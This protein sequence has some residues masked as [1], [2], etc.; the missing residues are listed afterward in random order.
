MVHASQTGDIGKIDDQF[1]QFIYIKDRIK[2]MYISGGENVYPAE[3]EDELNKM[4]EIIEVAIISEFLMKNGE[5]GCAFIKIKEG[6]MCLML[7]EYGVF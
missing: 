7:K 2:D 5:V 6:S 1:Q 3:V 4:S